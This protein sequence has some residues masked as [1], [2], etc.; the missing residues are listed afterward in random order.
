MQTYRET[1]SL[2][3][4]SRQVVRTWVQREAEQG[5]E[6]LQDR[7]RRPHRSPRQTA[8]ETE[9]LVV[10]ARQETGY[11]RLRLA[12]YLRQRYG[13]HLS[14]HTLRPILRR[15]GLTGPQRRRKP[16]KAQ[17]ADFVLACDPEGGNDLLAHYTTRC[18]AVPNSA[19]GAGRTTASGNSTSCCPLSRDLPR[20]ARWLNLC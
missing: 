19:V 13:V 8:P 6:G 15:H 3:H 10:Q 18:A 1:L 17:N 16:L 5:E 4:T 20:G 7:S 2:W 12:W 9:D 11:G 14:P